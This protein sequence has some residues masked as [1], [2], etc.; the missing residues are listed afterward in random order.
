MLPNGQRSFLATL[1]HQMVSKS[2]VIQDCQIKSKD[3]AIK[4][5]QITSNQNEA[6]LHHLAML[7]TSC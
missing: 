1:E 6:C 3:L 7:V 5:G 4:E 2:L